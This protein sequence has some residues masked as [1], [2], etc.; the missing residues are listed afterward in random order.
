MTP[1]NGWQASAQAHLVPG[2]YLLWAAIVI[3]L[4]QQAAQLA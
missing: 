1:Q 3:T 2:A 4:G